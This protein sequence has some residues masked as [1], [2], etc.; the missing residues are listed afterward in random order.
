MEVSY[1]PSFV[2]M[3]KSLPETLITE[4]LE[5]I[6]LFRDP[7]HHD[8]L[9]V[10]KLNGRMKGRFAFSVNYKTRVVFSYLKKSPKEALLHAIGDHDIYDR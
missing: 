7:K 2:R 10:H 6:D 8:P 1:T 9:R 5:K 3:L 4:A